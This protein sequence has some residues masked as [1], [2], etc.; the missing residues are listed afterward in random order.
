MTDKEYKTVL[1][2]GIIFGLFAAVLMVTLLKLILPAAGYMLIG[3]LLIYLWGSRDDLK[4]WY[5]IKKFK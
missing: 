2:A 5:K 1:E 4:N 3:T